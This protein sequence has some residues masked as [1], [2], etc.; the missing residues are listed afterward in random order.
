[1][2]LAITAHEMNTELEILYIVDIREFNW[3]MLV[4]AAHNVK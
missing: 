2:F 3:E 1:M 4:S